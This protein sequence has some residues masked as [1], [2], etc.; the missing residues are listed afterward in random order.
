MPLYQLFGGKARE[1]IELYA[2]SGLPHGV[3][4]PE[5]AQRMGLKERAAATMAAG[6]RVYRVDSGILPS[7][8]GGSN[9]RAGRGRRC[10][11]GRRRAAEPAVAAGGPGGGRGGS[12]FNTRARIPQ[13]I[14]ALEQIREGVGPDGDFMIDLHQKF[15]L[16][17]ASRGVPA[18]RAASAVRGRGPVARRAVP[19]PASEAAAAHDRADLGRRGVGHARRLQPARRAA[20][21][22]L[23][24]RAR[25]RTSAGSPRC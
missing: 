2:T 7:T 21:H 4:P 20:R 25:C 18:H 19:H 6:W 5:E 12:L 9:R 14:K 23:R 24:T 17:E 13:M 11:S 16:H 22:R 1:H 15:D 8:G 3:V 10:G